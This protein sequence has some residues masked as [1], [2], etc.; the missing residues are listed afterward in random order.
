MRMANS[1]SAQQI[2]SLDNSLILDNSLSLHLLVSDESSLV[3]S[4]G[5]LV[6][7]EGTIAIPTAKLVSGA[8]LLDRFSD[9][10]IKLSPRSK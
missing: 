9:T 10:S 2:S 5:F 7:D 8:L 4:N 6:L 1:K 3:I